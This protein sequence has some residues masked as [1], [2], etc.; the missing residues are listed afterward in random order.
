MKQLE[1][2]DLP[3]LAENIRTSGYRVG[4]TSEKGTIKLENDGDGDRRKVTAWSLVKQT[5]R[6]RGYIVLSSKLCAP[7]DTFY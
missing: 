5:W 2:E 1:F 6:G 7:L 3:H 4:G